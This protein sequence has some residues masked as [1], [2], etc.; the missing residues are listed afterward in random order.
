MNE[1]LFADLELLAHE[2]IEERCSDFN[3][4]L[5]S[6]EDEFYKLKDERKSQVELV[7][8]LRVAVGGIEEANSERKTLL[9]RFHEVKRIADKDRRNRDEVNRAIPPPA[10]VLEEWMADTY[11]KLTTIDNDLTAVP[12]LPRE[13]ETFQRFF[14][15]Q[16]AVVRKREAELAHSRYVKQI[17]VM[18][19]ITSGLDS[20]RKERKQKADSVTEDSELE[21]D[22]L[23]R[24]EIRK[25]SRRI[26]GIDKRMDKIKLEKKDIQK[27]S[28]RLKSYL[29]ITKGRGKPIRL[30][31]V[32][33]RASSGGAL[34]ATELSALLDSGGLANLDED[35][36]EAKSSQ[37]DSKRKGKGG[38][39]P[40]RRLGVTRAGPRKGNSAARRE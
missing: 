19:E 31:D 16:A 15:L 35:A 26:T 21:S 14:E 30:S 39:K 40:R 33:E 38:K 29:R 28:D 4:E 3:R 20:T 11:T 22:N 36:G 7:Q 6:L 27:E 24:K 37:S 23:T 32:K 18:R 9:K 17:E 2:E 12:T 13:L 5:R 25:M 10:S 34:N 8:S 1:T